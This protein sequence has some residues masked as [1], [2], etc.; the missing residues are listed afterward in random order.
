LAE[1]AALSTAAIYNIEAGRISNPQQATVQ[2]LQRALD[3]Q[4]PT[5]TKDEIREEATIAGV[6]E[7]VDFDPH[8]E[9]DLPSCPGIYVLYGVSER[10]IYV[11]QGADIKRRIRDHSEKFWFRPPIVETGAFVKINEKSL[12]EKVET[13]LIRFLKSNAVINKQNVDR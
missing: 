9:G 7:L 2:K 12:R 13:L 3:V 6:G 4:I 10:P 5:E 1:K 11:G 8:S